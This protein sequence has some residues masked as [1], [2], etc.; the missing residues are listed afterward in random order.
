VAAASAAVGLKAA[1]PR[2]LGGEKQKIGPANLIRSTSLAPASFL[3]VGK[4]LHD[5]R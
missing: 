3:L 2:A 5:G 4:A 1:K